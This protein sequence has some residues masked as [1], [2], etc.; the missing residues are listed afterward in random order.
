MRIRA[1]CNEIQRVHAVGMQGVMQ[2][3][4]LKIPTAYSTA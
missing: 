1:L 4:V 2:E 3:I